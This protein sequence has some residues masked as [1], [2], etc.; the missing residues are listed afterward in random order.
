MSKS[1]MTLQGVVRVQLRQ[2]R[3]ASTHNNKQGPVHIPLLVSLKLMQFNKNKAFRKRWCV[4]I[5]VCVCVCVC[6]WVCVCVCVGG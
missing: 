2:P 3:H 4:P 6:V 5:P 1:A